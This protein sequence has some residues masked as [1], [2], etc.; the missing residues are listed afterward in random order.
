MDLSPENQPPVPPE[1]RDASQRRWR[2][3]L[4]ALVVV[5]AILI[6]LY[7]YQYVTRGYFWQ[8]SFERIVSNKAGRPVKVAG[9]FQ[10]YL[11][12]NIRFHAEGLS[13]ANPDWAEQKQLFTARS[14][15]L[16]MPVWQ[17]I[18][19][20]Q[21]MRHLAIDGGRIG[22]QS[23]AKGR[24]TWTFPGN[25]P[26]KLPV[27]DRAAV[28]D[29]RLQY[30]DA[31]RRARVDLVFGDIA[32]SADAKG[33]RVAGPLTFTGRGTAYGAPF[34]LDGSLTT[35]NEAA[36]GGRIGLDLRARVA[37]T[38][39]TM[40]GTL[41]G[42]TRF[43]GADLT[44][45]VAGR[46][47][48]TPGR[49]F[50]LILPATRAYRLASHLTREG[51]DYQFT[52]IN[53]RFGDS[54]INGDLR[55]SA[56]ADTADK[57]RIN[58]KL[59][60]R[61]LD[62][63][64]VGPLVGYSPERLD[65]KGGKGAITIEAGRPRVLPDAPLAIEQLK[66]FDA[67][68][69]YTAGT[70][71][72]GTVPI[73]NLKLGFYLE[74]QKLDLDPLAFDVIGGRLD[75]TIGIDASVRP[76]LTKYDIRMSQ[77]PIGKVLTSFKVED[78]G[79]TAT[80][81]ARIQLT[82]RGDTV[83][84]SLATSSGRIALVFPKGTLW[85]RNIQLAKLDLQN[86]ITAALGKRLKKPTEIRCG[87]VAFTVTNGKAAADPILFDTTRANYRGRGGFDFSDES[88]ALSIEGGSKEF[89]IFSGQSPIGIN[90]W[91]AAPSI[92]PIS[93]EL[94]ARLGSGVALGLVAT[95]F[96]SILAFVDLGN[97]KNNDCQP[98]LAGARDNPADRAKNAKAKN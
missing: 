12:P 66:A 24:N 14:I 88:L 8:G 7:V 81:R 25:T 93:K 40:A 13:V 53:G 55:V 75:S 60:S 62:I 27:I 9:N 20:D 86:F 46:N 71:R 33:Q 63:L 21:I 87:I 26:L 50:G 96:A 74:N 22:L 44:V 2:Y 82:G 43:D 83:R 79:T 29:T 48:Q 85:V 76:V 89:S 59:N 58:G 45:S 34:T 77:V 30:I 56:P 68:V 57:F 18:F 19:G 61:V 23:D 98:I 69:D 97:A 84:K 41:P 15:D 73:A 92:N 4:G 28:T 10:L 54:D 6:G 38:A 39:I 17:L 11:D 72:T 80:M 49:L 67:H 5:L 94:L 37:D 65:A 16:D 47:L 51:R 32:G 35:P 90:G 31:L 42:A 78:N 70:V 36:I 52:R 64:D 3:G 95:P 91:F 1:R